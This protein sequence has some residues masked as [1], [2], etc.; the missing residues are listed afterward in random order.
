[1][2]WTDIILEKLPKLK[3]PRILRQECGSVIV[4]TAVAISAILGLAGLAYDVGNLYMH[5]ARL[6]NVADAAA[7]AGARAY[8]DSQKL[9]TGRDGLDEFKDMQSSA[10]SPLYYSTKDNPQTKSHTGT[11]HPLADKAA[12]DYI[13]NNIINLGTT[14]AS[15]GFSHYALLSNETVPKAFYR[16]GL[17]EYVDL[18]FMPVIRGINKQQKVAVEAIVKMSEDTGAD[19]P[20]TVFSNLFSFSDSLTVNAG[21]ITSPTGLDQN[22]SS[23]ETA[24]KIQATFDGEMLYTGNKNNT[25]DYLKIKDPVDHLYTSEGKTEQLSQDLSIQKM[26]SSYSNNPTQSTTPIDLAEYQAILNSKLE[27]EHIELDINSA[28][29]S[30]FNITNIN[31]L[32]HSLYDQQQYDS[33][34]NE[35]YIY[36]FQDPWTGQYNDIQYSVDKDNTEPNDLNR[37]FINDSNNKKMYALPIDDPDNPAIDDPACVFAYRKGTDPADP[38]KEGFY[39]NQGIYYEGH[40]VLDTN[41]NKIYYS[42]YNNINGKKQVCFANSNR[43]RITPYKIG[44]EY[45]H[46]S[47]PDHHIVFCAYYDANGD[48]VDI[49]YVAVK[50]ERLINNTKKFTLYYDTNVFHLTNSGSSNNEVTINIDK[51]VKGGGNSNQPLYIINDTNL[52]MKITVSADNVRPVAIIHNSATTSVQ[53]TVNNW[54][55]FTGMIYSPKDVTVSLKNSAVF[56]GN[57]SA[58][59]I[60]VSNSGAASFKQADYLVGDAELYNAIAKY[61]SDHSQL[62]NDPNPDNHERPPVNTYTNVWQQWYSIYGSTVAENWFNNILS[63]AQRVAFWRSWD[64][65]N[66]PKNADEGLRNKWYNTDWKKNWLFP[67]WNPSAENIEDAKKDNPVTSD[68]DIKVR[69]IDPFFEISPFTKVGTKP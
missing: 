42:F 44:K 12:D 66:R 30:D 11:P 3:M 51:E 14:V 57:V 16:I 20:T 27:Q 31:D 22:P 38:N 36:Q 1:M 13:Y 25:S 61:A 49:G 48:G 35:L 62:F 28:K 19:L 52:K 6:Q 17:Y 64:L 2:S 65:E 43:E 59:K 37:Y 7:L 4:F 26:G 58:K 63:E 40:Y 60:T 9:E 55:T 32:T 39:D 50:K 18:H 46:N 33:D 10:K 8:A 41:N 69:L 47:D 54:M 5:K 15:D 29:Y 56:S 24:S 67:S 45:G 53:L 34:N 21:T 68:A 23:G